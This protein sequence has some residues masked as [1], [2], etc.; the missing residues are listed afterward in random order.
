MSVDRFQLLRNTGQFDSVNAAHLPLTKLSLIY[1]ENGR[2]KTTLATILRSLSTGDAR[3]ISERQR[4]GSVHPP[5]IVLAAAGGAAHIFQNGAWNTALPQ[6]AVFDD[7]F[8]AQNVCS[9]IEIE[10]AHRQNLHELILGAQGVQLNNTLQEHIAA[11]EQHNRTL[12]ERG[13]AI[14]A[15]VRGTLTVDAFC[16]L[17]ADPQI[18]AK[19]QEAE[20]RL[21]AARSADAIQ[22]RAAFLP[23]ALPA[24]DIPALNAILARDLPALEAGAAAHV[25]AHVGRLGQGGETWIGQGMT[26]IGPVSE[27]HDHDICPFCAQDLAGSPLI[28]HYQAYFGAEYRSLKADI[29]GA[30]SNVN[31]AHGGDIPAAFERAVRETGQ[32]A[33]FWTQFTEGVPGIEVDTAAIARAWGAARTA[34]LEILRAK[35]AAPLEPTA[36]PAE[37]LEAIA[38]YD[39]LRVA[40]NDLSGRLQ[41]FN[42]PIAVVKEQAAGANIVTLTADLQRL[43]LLRTRHTDPVVGACAAYLTEKQAKTATERLRDQARAAL[44]QYRQQVFPA[45]EAAINTYLQRFNAGFRIGAVASV[46]NRAGSAANYNVVINN[47]PVALAADNGPSFR[48]TLSAGDRNTLALAF[49][50]A[51]LEQDPQLAQKIV[52]IDDPMTSLDEHRSLTTVLEMRRLHDR[53]SQIIVLSHSKPFLCALWE[54]A[55]TLTRTALRLTRQGAGSTL[56]VWDVNQDCITEHDRRHAL[57]SSYIEAGDPAQER[58]VA[59]A[60]RPI[61][62]AFVRVSYPG[63]F[64]P[65]SMLGHFINTCEQRVGTPQQILSRA[66]LDE[67]EVLKDYGNRF[68]HDTN[69]AWQTAVINDLELLDFC[70]RTLAFTRR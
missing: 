57:V 66:D 64:P 47:T 70:T 36:L 50:F 9:G 40:I 59:E 58:A 20:R 24:F 13:D 63:N 3:L 27:G 68:H 54:G 42:A 32:T 53:V 12:R 17:Q 2:G 19:I 65:G 7:A 4:L 46:N 15:A 31:A 29:A 67:L 16:A 62:E 22:R 25:Q 61:L 48:N 35:Q 69:P 56:A 49:F 39:E 5:H 1:A 11:V 43:T 55:D 51:S 37:T 26:R 33:E 45:Y 14:P 28:G 34:V 44:D 21:A 38:A 52:V 6:V 23:L 10:T 8:V 18:D 41:A 60:L 30:I